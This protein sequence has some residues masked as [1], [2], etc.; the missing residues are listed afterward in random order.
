MVEYWNN[1]KNKEGGVLGMG[2]QQHVTRRIGFRNRYLPSFIACNLVLASLVN[3][4]AATTTQEFQARIDQACQKGGGIVR[5]E[6][7]TY[8]VGQLFLKSNVTLELAEGALLLASTNRADYSLKKMRAFIGATGATNVTLR[9]KGIIDGRG[10]ALVWDI[11]QGMALSNHYER[12]S[13]F[14]AP[15]VHPR[16]DERERPFL[17]SFQG[18][19]NVVVKEVELRNGAC[20]MNTYHYCRGVTIDGIKITGRGFWNNDGIDLCDTSDVLVENCDIDSADDSICLKSHA[21]KGLNENIVIR[22]C[23]IRSSGSAIKFGTASAGT[24]RNIRIDNIEVYDTFRSAIAIESVD[25]S[26]IS[27][28]VVSDVRARNV[29]NGLF[30]RLGSR[31]NTGGSIKGISIIRLHAEIAEKKPDAGLEI[32][33]PP[34][35]AKDVLPVVIS[36]VP[37]KLI[38]DVTLHGCT[39][40]FPGGNPNSRAELVVAEETAKYPEFSMFLNLPAWAVYA[41]HIRKLDLGDSVFVAR[42]PDKRKKFAGNYF[43][44]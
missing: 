13:W 36:G 14:K 11:M 15:P 19:T 35:R 12:V 37:D 4:Y 38:E 42:K 32:E 31:S 17:L 5:I 6:K 39:F 8:V 18:C 43:E 9:G 44:K 2:C 29:G 25:G 27:D 23:K 10:R 41:R 33:G 40:V 28:V 24:F 16:P 34:I 26:D 30:V 3:L 1:G 21:L 20:W 7:G 22:N